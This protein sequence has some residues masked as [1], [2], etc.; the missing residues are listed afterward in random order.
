MSCARPRPSTRRSSGRPRPCSTSARFAS[1]SSKIPITS[2]RSPRR[3]MR[4]SSGASPKT[5]RPPLRISGAPSRRRSQPRSSRSSSACRPILRRHAS[6][7]AHGGR[8]QDAACEERCP[9]CAGKDRNGARRSA[10]RRDEAPHGAGSS[11]GRAAPR[12]AGG[13]AGVRAALHALPAEGSMNAQPHLRQTHALPKHLLGWQGR[14]P[15]YTSVR[16]YN[17]NILACGDSGVGKSDTGLG[18]VNFLIH[19]DPGRSV[20]LLDGSA[21]SRPTSRSRSMRRSNHSRP[22]AAT[23]K[24]RPL[25]A[26]SSTSRSSPRMRPASRS[27]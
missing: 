6:V 18:I 27:T 4:R 23:P 13:S 21:C 8:A 26:E 3:G 14:T 24:R 17:R 5:Q 7:A 11:R 2:G 1:R 12:S 19:A 10:A 9:H 15:V 25:R 20:M 16:D 22:R